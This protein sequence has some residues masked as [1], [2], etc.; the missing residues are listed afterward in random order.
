MANSKL[1][2]TIQPKVRGQKIVVEMDAERFE[3]LASD[4]GLFSP[5]FLKSLARSEKEIAQG[6]VYPLRS[7][8]ELSSRHERN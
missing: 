1:E 8:S 5:E 6:K 7:L 4:L 2:L 3:R